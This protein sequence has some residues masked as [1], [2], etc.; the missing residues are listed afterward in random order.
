MEDY[1]KNKLDELTE[2]SSP[3]NE[4]STP[5]SLT[6]YILVFKTKM[7]LL[8]NNCRS[9]NRSLLF[10]FLAI[11][12]ISCLLTLSI[13]QIY[14]QTSLTA[15]TSQHPLVPNPTTKKQGRYQN[16]TSTTPT[17]EELTQSE[18]EQL[19]KYYFEAQQKNN[20]TTKNAL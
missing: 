13:S 1:S 8:L 17:Q 3:K 18:I 19:L 12:I 10:S 20:S 11:A 9:N 16:N 5:S 2:E 6:K 4:I 14:L 15:T 7:K